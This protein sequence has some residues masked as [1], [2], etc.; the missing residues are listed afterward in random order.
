M[1]AL[2]DKT[3]SCRSLARRSL[4]RLAVVGAGTLILR[5]TYAQKADQAGSVEEVK[6]E[7]FAEDRIGTAPA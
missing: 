7:A 5:R 2:F 3:P 1:S 4:L 6:G